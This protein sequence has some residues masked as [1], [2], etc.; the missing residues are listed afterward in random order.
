[1]SSPDRRELILERLKVV[2]KVDGIKT[3]FRNQLT[4]PEKDRPSVTILDSDENASTIAD[5]RGRANPALPYYCTMT[6]EIYVNT[7]PITAGQDVGTLLN[8]I[9]I[10]L[11]KVIMNDDSLL[12]LTK[13]SDITYLGY[14]TGLGMGRSMEGEGGISFQFGYMVFP[15]KL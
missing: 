3:V 9:R 6:P 8:T 10:A 12:A 2:C 14:S 13:D 15:S 7:G 11:I 1:M 5:G 4:I